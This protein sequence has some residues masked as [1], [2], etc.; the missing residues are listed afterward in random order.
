MSGSEKIH[1]S[2][3]ADLDAELYISP[4]RVYVI[5]YLISPIEAVE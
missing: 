4:T 2:L 1:A 5:D 3:Y